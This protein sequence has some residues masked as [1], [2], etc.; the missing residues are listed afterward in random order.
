MVFDSRG[1]GGEARVGSKFRMTTRAAKSAKL[2][3]VAD[4]KNNRPVGRDEILV[5]ND[6]GMSVAEPARWVA[7]HQVIS[8]LIGHA[9][10]LH[11]EQRHINVLPYSSRIATSQGREDADRCVETGE[12]IRHCN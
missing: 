8:G 5:R 3:V 10:D 7:A 2:R 11:I 4:R 6:I 9:G 12:N 1:V